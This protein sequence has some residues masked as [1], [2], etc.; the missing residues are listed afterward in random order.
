M[1]A[2]T[3]PSKDFLILCDDIRIESGNKTS[4]L[5]YMGSTGTVV[6]V[7]KTDKVVL[8]S[9]VC[10]VSL[11]DGE[12]SFNSR[13]DLIDPAGKERVKGEPQQVQLRPGQTTNVAIKISPFAISEGR[14]VVRMS[15]D[16]KR[17][18][19]HFSVAMTPQA[20]AA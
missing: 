13:L 20:T 18:E 17:Y 4:L 10:V 9:I 15:L 5:G 14:Y 1:S 2:K 12:G 3:F 7:Q 11:L 6:N 8:S 19:Y 16:D